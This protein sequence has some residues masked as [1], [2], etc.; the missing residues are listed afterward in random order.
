MA[1]SALQ[2]YM[3]ETHGKEDWAASVSR[4]L[5][6]EIVAFAMNVWDG[7]RFSILSVRTWLMIMLTFFF[8]ALCAPGVF[9]AVRMQDSEC[10]P[11]R[12]K[13]HIVA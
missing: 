6:H 8:T 3:H 5:S 12:C 9:R 1:P 2:K 10:R 4:A 11:R 13:L 7:F